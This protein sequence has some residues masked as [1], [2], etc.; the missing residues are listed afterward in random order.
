MQMWYVIHE[1]GDFTGYE[2]MHLCG[3][4]HSPFNFLQPT[5][6][7]CLY[8]RMYTCTYVQYTYLHIYVQ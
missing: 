7:S 8:V 5:V 1:L 4:S 3:L 2:I 6:Y